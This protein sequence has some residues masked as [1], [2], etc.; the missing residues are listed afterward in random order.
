MN[1]SNPHFD[2]RFIFPMYGGEDS[3]GRLKARGM[4]ANQK[5]EGS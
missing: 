1:T 4:L 3:Y 2:S 5:C